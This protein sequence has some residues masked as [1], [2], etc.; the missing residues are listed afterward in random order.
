[1]SLKIPKLSYNAIL[2]GLESI[3]LA[4]DTVW[5]QSF[6]TDFY[7]DL[8]WKDDFCSKMTVMVISRCEI[9]SEIDSDMFLLLWRAKLGKKKW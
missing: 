5:A 1:M 8:L 6:F 7:E 2:N 4:Y 3:T 9:G